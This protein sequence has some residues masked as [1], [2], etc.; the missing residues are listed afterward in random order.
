MIVLFE[1]E[2][3]LDKKEALKAAFHELAKKDIFED[4][5]DVNAWQKGEQDEWS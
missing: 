5:K 1:K 4:I 2:E 3:V